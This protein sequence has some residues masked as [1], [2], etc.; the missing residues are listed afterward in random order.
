MQLT[1]AASVLCAGLY[2][3]RYCYRDQHW[4]GS[5]SK[6]AS[7]GLLALLALALG[8]PVLALALAL[9]AMGDLAL[10]RAGERMFMAGLV[11]F[12]LAHAVYIFM[13]MGLD[14]S[15]ATLP[16][17]VGIAFAVLAL[18]TLWWLLPYTGDL[19]VPVVV[20]V[21]LITAMG[22]TAWG[23]P[24]GAG[25]DD[26]G[27]LIRLGASLFIASDVVLSWHIFR[28]KTKSISRSIVLWLLYY[29]GQVALFNG[30]I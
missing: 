25:W 24:I 20:Y 4:L 19:R 14:F 8:A 10:S 21:L 22:V 17:S 5:L 23:Q 13:L 18:S 15:L 6:T 3:A 16:F 12:A 1:L 11:S 28:A 27:R 29:F 7:T 30:L 2:A 26:N 9:S